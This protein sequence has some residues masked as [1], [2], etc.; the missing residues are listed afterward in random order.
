[1]ATTERPLIHGIEVDLDE[2]AR[3]AA[4]EAFEEQSRNKIPR[5]LRR[6]LAK[7]AL[8][9]LTAAAVVGTAASLADMEQKNTQSISSVGET[10]SQIPSRLEIEAQVDELQRQ[11]AEEE[12]R[13]LGQIET[14]LNILHTVPREQWQYYQ[15]GDT[16][17]Q[18][19]Q[20]KQAYIYT[21]KAT[22]SASF[23]NNNTI[24]FTT[25]YESN[26]ENISVSFTPQA[27]QTPDFVLEAAR[28]QNFL[29]NPESLEGAARA[30]LEN[31][32]ELLQNQ[33]Q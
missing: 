8:T 10:S 13:Q 33:G 31:D 32:V 29:A 4:D 2:Q 19:R 27:T 20:Q 12:K 3:R 28:G 23:V 18:A 15:Y 24:I 17:A 25:S 14:S 6:E 5:Q 26:G 1:M 30:T 22:L 21:P 16:S 11:A 7:T 9:V